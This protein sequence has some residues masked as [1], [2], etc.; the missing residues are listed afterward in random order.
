MVDGCTF[1]VK[2]LLEVG[3]NVVGLGSVDAGGSDKGMGGGELDGGCGGGV[4]VSVGRITGG[5]NGAGDEVDDAGWSDGA[6]G[7]NVVD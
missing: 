5:D 7:M 6:G 3:T 4:W 2:S 1:Q